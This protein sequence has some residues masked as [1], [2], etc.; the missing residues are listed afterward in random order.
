M[1]AHPRISD[2]DIMTLV[3]AG[4]AT[5]RHSAL[6]AALMHIHGVSPRSARRA[7]AKAIDRGII[8]RSG[9]FYA[10]PEA[11]STNSTD[12]IDSERPGRPCGTIA[13]ECKSLV[14]TSTR[15]YRRVDR[16]DLLERLRGRTWRHSELLATICDNYGCAESTARRNV[17]LALRSGYLARGPDGYHMTTAA[18]AQLREYGRLHGLEGMRFARYCSGRPG[19]GLG[20]RDQFASSRKDSG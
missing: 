3:D 7:V 9:M 13:V 18:E 4:G 5:W 12:Q 2:T 8:A 15:R 10:T 1:A 11:M 19:L 17:S 20:A 6:V 14:H 16:R